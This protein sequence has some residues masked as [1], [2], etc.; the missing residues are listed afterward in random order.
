MT[1][2]FI[3]ILTEYNNRFI[4]SENP[5]MVMQDSSFDDMLK[6]MKQALAENEPLQFD[7]EIERDEFVMDALIVKIGDK[8]IN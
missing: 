3:E 2:E 4:S 7:Y 5:L 1:K 8:V 6:F